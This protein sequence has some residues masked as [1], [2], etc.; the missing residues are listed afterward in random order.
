MRTLDRYIAA[1]FLK[2][3]L[4]CVLGAPLLFIIIKLTDDLDTYLARGLSP[5]R[6]F[7]PTCTNFPSRCRCPFP[8]PL[9]SAQ[10][11]RSR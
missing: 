6:S 11:S 9:C 10:S 5:A 4:V 8:S 2:V 7:W 1:S 3:F